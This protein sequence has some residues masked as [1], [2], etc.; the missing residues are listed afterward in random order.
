MLRIDSFVHRSALSDLI[1]RW[2]VGKPARGDVMRLKRIVNF[3]SYIARLWVDWF[4]RT[5]LEEWHGTPP[6]LLWVS[7]KGE[8]KDFTISHVRY[9][10]P[11]IEEMIQRYRRF[12]E[13]FYRDTPIDGLIY[14]AEFD[15]GQQFV[16]SS[17][18]KRFRRIAEKGSRKIIDFMLEQIR[19]NA[20]RLAEQRA[21]SLG[22][23]KDQ[24]I[25]PRE[26]MVEEFYHAERQL[27][28]S[29]KHGTIAQDPPQVEIADVAGVKVIVEPDELPR[30]RDLV[31]RTPGVVIA[32]EEEHSG[33]YNG[34]NFK[35]TYTLP[36]ERLLAESPKEAYL[37]VLAYRGF[38]PAE[39][40][41]EYREFLEAAEDKV[42]FEMIACSFQEFLES[43]IGRSMHEER[44]QAQRAHG[45]YNG[46][47]A[48]NV[49][50]LMEYM[51]SVCRAP[52]CEDLEDIPI[53]LWVNYMP[54]SIERIVRKLYVPEEYFY[55]THGHRLLGAA[56]MI[57][58]TE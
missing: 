36:K 53:K 31:S 3:N 22:I 15:N 39:I 30:F 58:P 56:R 12:P 29:I 14:A 32:E 26:A 25:T 47:L 55:D 48:T 37:R 6:A 7:T 13:D 20:D 16:G 43:E 10:N 41:R 42:G 18:I 40:G 33:N 45:D 52:G 28:K 2:M 9:S 21:Q 54:D 8:L 38:D 4:A 34:I 23:P 57:Q 49:R 17:R 5:L 46:R 1:F 11:R 50:F 19:A 35:L 51:L 24:L 44:V 27:L